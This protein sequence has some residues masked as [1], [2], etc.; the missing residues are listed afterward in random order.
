M[1]SADGDNRTSGSDETTLGSQAPFGD[2]HTPPDKSLVE[3]REVPNL[4]TA[5]ESPVPPMKSAGVGRGVV[6]TIGRG[7]GM[8]VSNGKASQPTPRAADVQRDLR[9]LNDA[10]QA[11]ELSSSTYGG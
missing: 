7:R 3:Q 1:V 5:E 11:A 10:R 4:S 2:A 6:R 9:E 8:R